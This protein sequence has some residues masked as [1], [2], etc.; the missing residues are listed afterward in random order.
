MFKKK[1]VFII[2]ALCLFVSCLHKKAPYK[3]PDDQVMKLVETDKAFSAD[4]KLNGMKAAFM[5]YIDSN[6]VLL[7]PNYKPI[8]GADAIDFISQA[9]DTSYIMT[10]VPQGAM[11]ASSNDMGY[12]Y[13][14][15][16]IQP[17][18]KDTLIHGTYLTI[19]KKEADGTWKFIMDTGNEGIG[20][21]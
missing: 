11:V 17:K 18:D 5:D 10:W 2:P 21:R 7:R 12:T 19:W 4:S 16:S 15:Y 9:N 3:A 6:G 14:I 20:D 1:I 13:G 8:E